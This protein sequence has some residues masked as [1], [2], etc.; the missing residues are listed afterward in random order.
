MVSW[1]VVVYVLVY[2]SFSVPPMLVNFSPVS[3]TARG[4]M[5]YET[6]LGTVA[7]FTATVVTFYKRRM[8]TALENIVAES[9]GWQSQSTKLP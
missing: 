1:V 2:V 3:P 5:G 8:T 7:F 6:M 4:S 9:T